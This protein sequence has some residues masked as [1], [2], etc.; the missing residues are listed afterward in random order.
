MKEIIFILNSSKNT[1]IN[2]RDFIAGLSS[3]S[4]AVSDKEILISLYTFNS[5]VQGIIDHTPPKDIKLPKE[6][7]S[8]G[9][10]DFYNSVGIVLERVS[11]RINNLKG[12]HIPEK[13][14]IVLISESYPEIQSDYS[15]DEI[16][17]FITYQKE[18]YLWDFVFFGIGVKNDIEGLGLSKDEIYKIDCTSDGIKK[19][20]SSL[21]ERI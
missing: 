11:D 9:E 10:C 6:I 7:N 1:N 18:D 8:S 15:K 2:S 4:K 3:F 17:T 14:I 13:V 19:L 5:N 12:K 16:N 21:V 20:F